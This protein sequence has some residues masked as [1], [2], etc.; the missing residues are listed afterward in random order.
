VTRPGEGARRPAHLDAEVFDLMT[1]WIQR[2]QARAEE[3]FTRLDEVLAGLDEHGDPL[4]Q[5]DRHD[6]HD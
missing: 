3:R 2:Y 1:K 4:P 6:L 5:H